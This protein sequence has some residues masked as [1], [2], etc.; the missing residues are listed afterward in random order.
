MVFAVKAPVDLLPLVACAPLQPPDA[1]Q[2]VALALDQ[3]S[4]AAEPE[5]TV[6]GLAL[7]LTVG[8]GELTVM[9]TDCEAAP[10][11]PSQINW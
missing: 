5:P 4:V 8:S 11:G 7:K 6:L 10:P 1:V 9:M 3:V 2:A